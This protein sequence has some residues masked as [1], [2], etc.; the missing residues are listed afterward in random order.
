MTHVILH[1]LAAGPLTVASLRNSLVQHKLV[2]PEHVNRMEFFDPY[3][4]ES[5]A[6]I[7]PEDVEWLAIEQRL[8][9]VFV[10]DK[11]K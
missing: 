9:R 1:P 10:L 5:I 3:N 7:L 8:R 6:D 11:S 2:L 4:G